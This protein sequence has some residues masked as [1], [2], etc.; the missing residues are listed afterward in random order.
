MPPFHGR[1]S[2]SGWTSF[3][4]GTSITLRGEL[5]ATV[6]RDP[7]QEWRGL[8]AHSSGCCPLPWAPQW[9]SNFRVSRKKVAI[10]GITADWFSFPKGAVQKPHAFIW[11]CKTIAGV[12]KYGSRTY[13]LSKLKRFE[14]LHQKY[15]S[16]VH[17]PYCHIAPSP[18]YIGHLQFPTSRPQNS[19]PWQFCHWWLVRPCNYDIVS[20]Q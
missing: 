13:S 2:A 16:Q 19:V 3:H 4:K 8:M 5:G 17:W 6:I 14:L 12:L 18:L 11:I 10:V 20:I 9:L 1:T 7:A 15:S